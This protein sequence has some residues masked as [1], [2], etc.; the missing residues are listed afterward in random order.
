MIKLRNVSKIYPNGARALI[1]VNLEIA[2]GEFVFLVGPS[3]AGKSTLIKLLY[4]EETATRGQVLIN[5]TN[6]V[7]LNH[8]QIPN[9]RRNIGVIFQDFKLLPNK[10]VFE[11]VAFALQVM[12]KDKKEVR[13]N[14]LNML[15]LVGLSRKIN[16]FPTELS[17]GEQ[18]RVCVARAL[19]NRP[20]LLVADEPTGNLDIDTAWGIMELLSRINQ[21]GTTIVM[22]THAL[23]I[24]EQ[25][26]KRV[27]RVEGG[28]IIEDRTEEAFH[29]GV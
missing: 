19:V 5:N 7:R 8:K 2:K 22:A 16:A 11:N 18:Q 29:F 25:M 4:R 14:T 27:V 26:N 13:E 6:L 3:G 24:V 10:T 17:G 15:E 9:I 21:Y 23:H 20:S 28:K 1:N 12:A